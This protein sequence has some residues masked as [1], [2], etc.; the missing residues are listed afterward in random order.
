VNRFVCRT[1]EC[2]VVQLDGVSGGTYVAGRHLQSTNAP[3]ATN[4]ATCIKTSGTGQSCAIS[5]SSATKNNKAVVYENVF[6]NSGLVQSASVTVSITQQASASGAA[7][8]AC[9]NQVINM[10]GSTTLTG[11]KTQ[12]VNVALEAHQSITITQDAPNGSNDASQSANQNGTCDPTNR[13]NQLQKLT[14]T[15]GGPGA[16][17]VSQNEDAASN[18]ANLSLDIEQNQGSGFGSQ[19]SLTNNA[20]FTQ[21][22]DLEAVAFTTSGATVNQ[23]QSTSVGGIVG[24]V[25]QD[26]HGMSTAD[27]QQTETQC[28]DADVTSV[29]PGACSSSAANDQVP[30]TLNQ[31]QVGPVK[32]GS[33]TSSQTGGNGGDTFTINQ[34]STQANDTGSGQTNIVQ[35]DCTTPGNCTDN[36]TTTVNGQTT[37]NTQT[38]QSVNTQ[39][40]CSGSSCTSSGPTTTGTL[41]TLPSG[42]SVSNTDVAEFGQGGMRGSGTSSI[43][44]SGISG[45]VLHAFLYWHGPTNSTDPNSNASVTFNGNSVTGTNIGTD[46]DNNWGFL[47]S[48][49]YR[50]DVTGLVTGN[51]T[52]N[53]TNFIKEN[54]PGA[55]SPP[56]LPPTTD[57]VADINGVALIVFYDDGNSSNDRNV[58][59][60]NG[61]DSNVNDG[62]WDET[63]SGVQYP[64]S[65]SASL[66]LVVSDGQSYPDGELDVNGNSVAAAGGIFQ[67]S[68]GPNYAGNPQGV[69]GSLWD[70]KS[71]DITSLLSQGSNTLHITSPTNADALSLVVAIAN[72]PASAQTTLF[73]PQ[74]NA[75]QPHVAPTVSTSAPASSGPR[76]AG[77]IR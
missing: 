67:G 63:L 42:L 6:K 8:T 2:A 71:F 27:A 59:L 51:G 38:G 73:A 30:T 45:P 54:T 32:K 23:T 17:S 34:T 29:Q 12:P 19:T 21:S 3:T 57:C 39:T 10:D 20:T 74:A 9:V 56:T 18:G 22:S 40:T 65:G 44:V 48:Q 11:K 14:S 61:N 28:E 36:Q 7:N 55:C 70:V 49:S 75:L 35:G 1:A 69:T 68:T 76:G 41:T 33:G 64:G 50:A 37:N 72:V 13:L 43:A 53:L 25:N 15:A 24:T 26:S 16:S 66:D 31:T 62:T 58:V 47:N 52:Y 77:A 4:T 46:S 5:Q 60:W